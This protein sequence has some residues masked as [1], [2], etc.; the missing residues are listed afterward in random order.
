M[1]GIPLGDFGMRPA[2]VPGGRVVVRDAFVS[3]DGFQSVGRALENVASDMMRQASERSREE[4]DRADRLAATAR[5]MSFEVDSESIVDDHMTR[6]RA[7]EMTPDEVPDR[8]VSALK[9]K[10]SELLDGVNERVSGELQAGFLAPTKRAIIGAGDKIASYHRG[11]QRGAILSAEG[12][13]QQLAMTDPGLAVAQHGALLDNAGGVLTPEEV[14]TKRQAFRQN[15]WFSYFSRATLASEG[16]MKALETVKQA[17][18]KSTDLD[19]DKATMLIDRVQTAQDRLLAQADAQ[20]KRRVIEVGKAIDSQEEVILRGWPADPQQLKVITEAAKGTE[21][22]EDAERLKR[23]SS[24]VGKFVN[25]SPAA[26]EQ[27]LARLDR[28]LNAPGAKVTPETL[29]L[30]DKLRTL[31]QNTTR[32]LA[33][34]PMRYAATRNLIPPEPID[35]KSKEKLRQRINTATML[36]NQF[37]SPMKIMLPEE[38]SAISRVLA[39]ATPDEKRDFFKTLERSI[40][41]PSVYASVMGQLVGDS[42]VTAL[43]GV[44]ASRPDLKIRGGWLSDDRAYSAR[45]VSDLML[46]GESLLNPNAAEKATDGKAKPFP[47]PEDRL[48]NGEFSST[49]DAPFAGAPQARQAS[50]QAARA[51]YAAMSSEAGDYSGILNTERWKTAAQLAT[52]GVGR[53]NGGAVILPWGLNEAELADRAANAIRSQAGRSRDPVDQL[54]RAPL[55]NAGEGVFRLRRGTGYYLDT[56][57]QPLKIDVYS[58]RRGTG[59]SAT[60]PQR[61]TPPADPVRPAQRT[62]RKRTAKLRK[63]PDG[64]WIIEQDATPG[65]SGRF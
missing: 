25:A 57:G 56:N 42:P 40:D 9:K 31:H 47:M 34:D 32:Q 64:S 19:P 14:A 55:E 22:A 48:T 26:M 3:G 2:Q 39:K 44:I 23:L 11:Q 37:G 5:L 33:E 59:A 45:K 18:A 52:G 62:A 50:Y 49:Y 41:D 13:L 53:I 58:Y 4:R 20:R 43:A 61:S 27:E 38:A 65:A 28:D 10:Q 12:S 51:V 36:R 54:L 6:L 35:F 29:D 24:Y 8:I 7:G 17:V 60:I 21:L 63:E 16:S 1:A 30:R 46:A 15:T